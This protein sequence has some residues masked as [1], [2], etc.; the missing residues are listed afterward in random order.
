METG[1]LKKWESRF[2]PEPRQCSL[3]PYERKGKWAEVRHPDLV[4]LASLHSA[5]VYLFIGLAFSFLAFLAEILI[6]KVRRMKLQ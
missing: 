6:S 4:N 1:L 5:F 2:L 3:D